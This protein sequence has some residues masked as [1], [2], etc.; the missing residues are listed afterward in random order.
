[1]TH[2]DPHDALLHVTQREHELVLAGS[3]EVLAAIDA[4]RRELLEALA[5]AA[6]PRA[7]QRDTLARAYRLQAQTSDLLA[8]QIAEVRRA[9]GHVAKGR[10]AVQGYGAGAPASGACGA[11]VDLSG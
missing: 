2:A 9:I 4:E 5:H 10:D 1:M 11:R 7:A 6:P 8:A 3:W